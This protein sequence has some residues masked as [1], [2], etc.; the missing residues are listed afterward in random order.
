MHIARAYLVLPANSVRLHAILNANVG[1]PAVRMC[2]LL[3]GLCQKCA[4]A[5]GCTVL[6]LPSPG[7]AC[8]DAAQHVC[9]PA[10]AGELVQQSD[11]SITDCLLL[12]LHIDD[13][14]LVLTPDS[15]STGALNK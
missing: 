2:R 12:V 4:G 13:S 14:A 15:C 1:S 9:C 10:A 5:A 6:V 8:P 11:A 3:R 7:N